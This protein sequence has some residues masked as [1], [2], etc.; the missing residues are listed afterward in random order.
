MIDNINL[1]LFWVV[2]MQLIS[3]TLRLS[4]FCLVLGMPSAVLSQEIAA[5][6]TPVSTKENQIYI[7]IGVM[8]FCNARRL[9]VDFKKAIFLASNPIAATIIKNHGSQID[10]PGLKGKKLKDQAVISGITQEIVA[11][12]LDVKE[13]VEFVPIELKRQIEL[14]LKDEELAP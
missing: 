8:Y 1:N 6:Q 4:I 7:D 11:N 12:A 9:K 5:I 2:R 14:Q 10:I 3:S 13:C